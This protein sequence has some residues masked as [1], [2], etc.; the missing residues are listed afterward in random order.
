MNEHNTVVHGFY[1]VETRPRRLRLNVKRRGVTI[2]RGAPESDEVDQLDQQRL[3][4]Q[5]GRAQARQQRERDVV[6]VP[7]RRPTENVV[8][9]SSEGRGRLTT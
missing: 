1:G 8:A 2:Y 6:I 4:R 3:A 7:R 9:W 5:A